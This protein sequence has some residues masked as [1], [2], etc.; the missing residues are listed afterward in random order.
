VFNEYYYRFYF[1][2]FAGAILLVI[3][4]L[5]WYFWP[6]PTCFD[7]K[8]NGQEEGIDCGGPCIPCLGEIKSITV[9]LKNGL[10]KGR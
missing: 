7:K 4:A 9:S 1:S 8:Q 10:H 5:A 2:I 3:I 6:R